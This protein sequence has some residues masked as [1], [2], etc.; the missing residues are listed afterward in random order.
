[1]MLLG[2]SVALAGCAGGSVA[3]FDGPVYPADA[4]QLETLNIQAYAG[5]QQIVLNSGSA[6]SF[7][8]AEI[9][10]NQ[11]WAAEIDGLP[12][13]AEVS[14]PLSRFRNEFG[15]P[16]RGGG[17]F[18]TRDADEIVLVELR[19]EKGL[20]GVKLARASD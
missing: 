2:S 18:A 17:F 11:W 12:R 16:P 1:M 8:P 15:L 5:D 13:G 19:T 14:I 4:P 7:G 20:H 3:T 6:R 10:L 9:W